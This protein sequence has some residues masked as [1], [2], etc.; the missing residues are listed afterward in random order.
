MKKITKNF[1]T[2]Q[3][4]T[5]VE[6]LGS[7]KPQKAENHRISKGNAF[8]KRLRNPIN[9]YEAFYRGNVGQCQRCQHK[10]FTGPLKR[11]TQQSTSSQPKVSHHLF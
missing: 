8:L 10:L 5:V 4:A 9:F 7:Q 11:H 1:A 3:E 2:E 6:R